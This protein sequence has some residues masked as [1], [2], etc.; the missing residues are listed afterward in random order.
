[1]ECHWSVRRGDIQRPEDI[2]RYA[3]A[4]LTRETTSRCVFPHN[5]W[6]CQTDL[7]MYPFVDPGLTLK[8]PDYADEYCTFTMGNLAPVVTKMASRRT[9]DSD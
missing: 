6:L 8:T 4:I 7:R 2:L 9:V 3:A 1:M 5:L